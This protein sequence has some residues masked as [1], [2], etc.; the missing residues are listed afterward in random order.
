MF[1][2]LNNKLYGSVQNMRTL[3]DQQGQKYLCKK[4][5]MEYSKSNE[6]WKNEIILNNP[7]VTVIKQRLNTNT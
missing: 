7:K 4:L 3:S 2:I 1:L 5:L 6:I